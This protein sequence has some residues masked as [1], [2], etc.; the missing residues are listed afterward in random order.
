MKMKSSKIGGSKRSCPW[1]WKGN[2]GFFR[3]ERGRLYIIRRC[4]IML[5]CWH[6]LK[7]ILWRNEESLYILPHG[8]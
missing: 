1:S 2:G 3:E 5:L 8:S 7:Y 6:D 4:I